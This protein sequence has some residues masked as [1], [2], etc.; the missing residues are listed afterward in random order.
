VE[1][2]TAPVGDAIEN[3]AHA[4]DTARLPAIVTV[5]AEPASGADA[6]AEAADAGAE[7]PEPES[8]PKPVEAPARKPTKPEA[9]PAAKADTPAKKPDDAPGALALAPIP[10]DPGIDGDDFDNTA[11][12]PK[13]LDGN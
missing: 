13:D 11:A 8:A 4:D 6:E 12:R 7:S 10:D 5:D 3:L 2:A 1:G 9:G